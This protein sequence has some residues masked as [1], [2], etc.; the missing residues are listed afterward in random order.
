MISSTCFVTGVKIEPENR[1]LYEGCAYFTEPLFE[2]GEAM[3]PERFL[4]LAENEVRRR[5]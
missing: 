2:D 5:K 3:A 4:L 1:K